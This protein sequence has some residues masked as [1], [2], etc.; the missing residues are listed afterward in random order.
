M[1]VVWPC[2]TRVSGLPVSSSSGRLLP[3]RKGPGPQLD[4]WTNLMAEPARQWHLETDLVVLGSGGGGLTGAIVARDHGLETV[5]LEKLERIG[6]A[7]ALSGGLLW[8]PLTHQQREAGQKDSREAALDYIRTNGLG[9]HDEARAADYIDKGPETLAYIEQQTPLRWAIALSASDYYR[10][11]PA[12]NWG[13]VIAPDPQ[14]MPPVLEALEKRQP[15][16]SQVHPSAAGTSW[17]ATPGSSGGRA[18]VGALLS[19]CIDRRIPILTG[20]AAENLLVEDGRVVGVRA[21]RAGAD[22]FVRARRGVLIATGGFEHNPEMV[23]NYLGTPDGLHPISTP[24]NVGDG[25][26][27]AMEIGAGTAMMHF[28]ILSAM[29]LDVSGMAAAGGVGAVPGSI[30]V[31]RLGKRCCNESLYMSVARAMTAISPNRDSSW[32]NYPMYVVMD[33]KAAKGGSGFQLKGETLAALAGQIGIDAANLEATVARYNDFARKGQDPDFGRGQYGA[34]EPNFFP[35]T[36]A[37]MGPLETPPFYAARLGFRCVGT[38][39]GLLTDVHARALSL[40]GA[41]IPGLYATSNAAAHTEFGGG[42]TSGQ[43]NGH[44]IVFGYIAALHA[45]QKG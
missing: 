28:G 39:G 2:Q 8:V 5:V 24:G 31:N 36:P 13:R 1:K 27:M 37:T 16:L 21:R 33:A 29:A 4:P 40:R 25:H 7:H 9:L 11:I 17:T 23:K 44:S 3:T 35:D 15:L 12:F 6:G 38:K 19:A 41:V 26:L 14:S 43:A 45:A 34:Y 30:M 42:Y 20:V 10:H 18:I 22:Y 32:A